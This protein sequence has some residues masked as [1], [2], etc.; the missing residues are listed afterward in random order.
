MSHGETVEDRISL[1]N[2]AK[3]VLGV[4]LLNCISFCV[5][6]QIPFSLGILFVVLY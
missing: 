4:V 6:I 5:I 2:E 1:Q 3:L